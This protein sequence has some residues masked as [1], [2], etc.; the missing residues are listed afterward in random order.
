MNELIRH[1]WI[2]KTWV[3]AKI[4]EINMW[5]NT[6]TCRPTC[7]RMKS[8]LQFIVAFYAARVCFLSTSLLIMYI[9]IHLWLIIV[10]ISFINRICQPS[11]ITYNH[12]LPTYDRSTLLQRPLPLL[13]T[14][15]LQCVFNYT[16]R[17]T[18]T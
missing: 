18:T 11:T 4:I 8:D 5:S 15:V 14:G 12:I 6:N 9:I 1:S 17:L 2:L 10:L 3:H 7:S 13:Y 16:V